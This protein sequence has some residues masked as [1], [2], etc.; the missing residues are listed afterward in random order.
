MHWTQTPEGRRKISARFKAF[1]KTPEGKRSRSKAAE[2][3]RATA[4]RRRA[5]RNGQ[6]RAPRGSLLAPSGRSMLVALA[7]PEAARRI[8]ELQKEIEALTLFLEKTKP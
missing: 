4:A 7:R 1:Y 8:V 3:T 2:A 5:E 6:P